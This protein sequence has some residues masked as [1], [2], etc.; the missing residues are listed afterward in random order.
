MIVGRVSEVWR[1]AVKSVGGERL[2]ACTVTD[3]G[4]RGDRGWALRDET[5]GE[6]RGAKYLPKLMQCSARYRDEPMD[7]TI[8]HVDIILP[9][10]TQMSSDDADVN[11]RL[12]EFLGRP[13]SLWPLQ[14]AANRAHYKRAQ[15]RSAFMGRLSRSRLIKPY[16]RDFIRLA[17]LDQPA[18]EMF[19]RE[20]DEPLPDFSIIPS[21]LFEFTSP[22]GTYFDAF[23]I[24]LLTTSSL[25]AMERFNPAALWDV[26]RF[27]PNFLVE[28][29]EGIEGLVEA[30]WSGRTL[31]LGEVRLKCEIP[32]VR[33]GMTT[34][35]QAELPKDST[36]LRTI[37]RDGG[38]NL[39]VYASVTNK[40]RVSVGD[41]VEVL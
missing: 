14:P 13:V 24:H 18:R 7:G 21:E 35:A 36:V 9:D 2:D 11:G 8:P 15:A 33:C 26:R 25:A 29:V 23:P 10:G 12:S 16:L 22:P 31:Q 39:G 19:S 4:I 37:V 32:T 28:T 5:V 6:I 30:G 3:S 34:H 27:R 40:G 38:Q 41:A 1:Y 17:R 20:K